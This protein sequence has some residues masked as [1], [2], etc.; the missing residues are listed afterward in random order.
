MKIA[1]EC[2]DIFDKA[3]QKEIKVKLERAIKDGFI[4]DCDPDITAFIIY[5]IYIALM[6]DWDKPLDKKDATDRIMNVLE[7]GLFS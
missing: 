5:K 7:T 6:F 3:I 2:A 1:D 4:K